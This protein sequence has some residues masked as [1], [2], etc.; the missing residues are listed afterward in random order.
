MGAPS[1][2]L[3]Y[4]AVT[5][6]IYYLDVRDWGG[7][8]SYQIAW[9]VSAPGVDV[10]PPSAT[11]DTDNGEMWFNRAVTLTIYA[12]D[13][14]YGSGVGA[15]ES[16]MDDGL[17]WVSGA[18]PT[19][20]APA[21]HSNDGI[22]IVRFRAHDLSGNVSAASDGFVG[23][24]TVGPTTETWAPRGAVRQGHIVGLRFDITDLTGEVTAQL[25]VT[26]AS[27]G[28]VVKT[29]DIGSTMASSPLMPS[30]FGDW[31][32]LRCDLP[33]GTYK[34]LIAGTTHDVAGNPWQSAVCHGRLRVR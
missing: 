9:T 28:H 29:I 14:P 16:S 30:G 15:I 27:S 32:P 7:A 17:T 13:G 18:H 34:L 8:G 4:C 19:V 22:H 6:G 10:T 31:W 11:M 1:E 5:S 25:L 3:T 2:T 12:D 24:D 23:I 20:A 33:R 26:S 21:D